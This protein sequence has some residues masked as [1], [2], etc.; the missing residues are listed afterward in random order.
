[1]V[2]KS[3]HYFKEISHFYRNNGKIAANWFTNRICG[4]EYLNLP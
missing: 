1:M 3:F 4:S 2:N